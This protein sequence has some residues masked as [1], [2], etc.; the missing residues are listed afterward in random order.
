MNFDIINSNGK[1]DNK[2]L[3]EYRT[4]DHYEIINFPPEK[5][6]QIMSAINVSR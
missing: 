3:R 1:I 2:K 4:W 5:R 6:E